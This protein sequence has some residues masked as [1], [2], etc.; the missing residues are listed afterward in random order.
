MKEFSN[1]FSFN[2]M[3]T[4]GFFSHW[5]IKNILIAIIL[6][7]ILIIGANIGLR[8]ITKHTE[9]LVVPDLTNLSITEARAL[10]TRNNMII[11][12]TDSIYVKRMRRGLVY[13]QTPIAGDLV[14]SGRRISLTIN[15]IMEK[16]V[17]MPNLI[18]YSMRQAMSELHSRGLKIGKLIYRKDIATN[19][20]L[21]Q[22]YRNREIK[23]GTKLDSESSIDL[24]LGLNS[25]DNI[26][27]TPMTLG[28]KYLN[29]IDAV[30]NNSMNISNL[31]F[32]NTIKT[33]SNSLN[34]VV[35]SQ[36]P[37]YSENIPYRMGQ[38]MT[39]HL[40]LDLNKVPD[41]ETF[42]KEDAE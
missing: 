19:N 42:L 8:I 32:D 28:L 13:R 4:K 18:G 22:W 12:I 26:T 2:N 41:I 15:S 34:A 33:Y 7:A 5:I 29:A 21:E 31:R 35:Y 23:S 17:S 39:L 14:K 37:E 10:A 11:D 16:Q 24:I 3:E 30:H 20:V 9:K 38:D 1:I 27:Y 40:T 36:Y 25:T 6:V